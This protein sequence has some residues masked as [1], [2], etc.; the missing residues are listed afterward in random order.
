MIYCL[1][2]PTAQPTHRGGRCQ[3]VLGGALGLEAHGQPHDEADRGHPHEGGQQALLP[4]GG[5]CGWSMHAQGLRAFAGR[6]PGDGVAPSHLDRQTGSRS[7][8]PTKTHI[9]GPRRGGAVPRLARHLCHDGVCPGVDG[10]ESVIRSKSGPCFGQGPWAVAILA[11]SLVGRARCDSS[12]I[13]L[14][15]R[16]LVAR[17]AH[18][19][20]EQQ[21]G[22]CEAGPLD[23]RSISGAL[24]LD[25]DPSAVMCDAPERTND[26]DIHPLPLALPSGL[27]DCPYESTD[28]GWDTSTIVARRVSGLFWLGSNQ[29]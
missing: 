14:V 20:G 16:P 10:M 25:I 7:R 2:D 28:P 17:A 5:V 22:M 26:P 15:W 12:S 21:Q 8:M 27:I 11:R 19:P 29:G 9:P 24:P 23:G 4:V 18:P 3:P 1:D 6:W 13:A